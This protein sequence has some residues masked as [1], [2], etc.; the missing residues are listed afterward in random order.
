MQNT[1]SGPISKKTL[2]TVSIIADAVDVLL[3]AGISPGPWSIITEGPVTV[4]HF[5]Y[6]GP[7]AIAVLT[8]FIPIAG[9]L[10]IYTIA[11]L[12]YPNPNKQPKVIDVRTVPPP[13]HRPP[14]VPT[15]LPVITL[16]PPMPARKES[17]ANGQ[18]EDRL[19]KLDDLFQRKL[20]TDEEYR[21]KRQE[22]LTEI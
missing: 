7:R 9:F 5:M 20:I 6:A 15:D 2:L 22:I 8:E 13:M 4:M 19:R 16:P 14:V 10:P 3:L 21:A 17:L 1:Q 18:T 12:L 11:A